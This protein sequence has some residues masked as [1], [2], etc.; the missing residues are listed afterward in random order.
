MPSLANGPGGSEVEITECCP[1]T[2]D[3]VLCD[4]KKSREEKRREERSE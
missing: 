4:K 3:L 1:P 2:K